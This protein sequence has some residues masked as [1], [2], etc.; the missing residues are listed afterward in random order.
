MECDESGY[1]VGDVIYDI[2]LSIYL[3]RYT[4]SMKA[5]LWRV[6]IFVIAM[7]ILLTLLI[8]LLTVKGSFPSTLNNCAECDV[9]GSRSGVLSPIYFT[10][11]PS[12][13]TNQLVNHH[14]SWILV[15]LPYLI[16]FPV[17]Y[18]LIDRQYQTLDV[19]DV[20]KHR[21]GNELNSINQKITAADFI[22]QAK[23]FFKDS[24]REHH[25]NWLQ[26]AFLG[27]GAGISEDETLL[28]LLRMKQNGLVYDLELFE[29]PVP[30]EFD[31]LATA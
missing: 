31:D 26:R 17:L 28:I 14:Y 22:A 19:S 30:G 21:A 11:N 25:R 4:S 7:I 24:G 5:A 9:Y 10:D 23:L 2:C 27:F 15:A 13:P 18:D 6:V 16:I 8:G 1:I 29:F 3:Y 20:M 12:S